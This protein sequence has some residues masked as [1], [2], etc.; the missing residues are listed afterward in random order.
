MAYFK[1]IKYNRVTAILKLAPNSYT[2]A[3]YACQ[4]FVNAISIQES[5]RKQNTQIHI[6][7]QLQPCFTH[8]YCNTHNSTSKIS[9]HSP[10]TQPQPTA[11]FINTHENKMKINI[12][13]G[14]KGILTLSC[15]VLLKKMLVLFLRINIHS[16]RSLFSPIT[17]PIEVKSSLVLTLTITTSDKQQPEFQ[18][19]INFYSINSPWTY[20]PGRWFIGSRLIINIY[21]AV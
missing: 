8:L 9:T 14:N 6:Y 5:T 1:E 21:M 4:L 19:P 10:T 13:M 2:L 17:M 18:A 16:T 20:I 3:V 12:N 7:M 11:I 15:F